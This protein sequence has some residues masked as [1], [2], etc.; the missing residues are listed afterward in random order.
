[1]IKRTQK[2]EERMKKVKYGDREVE[3]DE[4]A[5]CICCDEP[6]H[7]ASMGGTVLCP[8]CDLGKCR[9]CG[10]SIFVMKESVDGGK[11]KR[12]VLEHMK[13]HREKLGLPKVYTE[14][15]LHEAIVCETKLESKNG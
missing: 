5:P 12:N 10:V 13:Y 2:G 8:A 11:S 4:L 9:F 14:K 15:E 1:M 3:Y 6:V 7:N